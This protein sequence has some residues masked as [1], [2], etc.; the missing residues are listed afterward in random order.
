MTTEGTPAVLPIGGWARSAT[1]DQTGLGW[2]AFEA[3]LDADQPGVLWIE[4]SVDGVVWTHRE[5][6]DTESGVPTPLSGYSTDRYLRA[7]WQNLGIDDTTTCV[8]VTSQTSTPAS[9]TETARAET[10][11]AL[12]AGMGW[13]G[14]WATGTAYALSAIV[15]GSDGH[16]YISVAAGNAAHNPVG[17]GGVHWHALAS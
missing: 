16:C 12:L 17:D 5:M 7:S 13:Q 9:T 3:T 10:A 4:S 8:M 14:V 11:E 15:T 2:T 6:A 1:Y